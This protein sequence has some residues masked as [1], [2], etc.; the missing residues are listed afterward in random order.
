MERLRSISSS[1]PL[2]GKPV[3]TELTYTNVFSEALMS[4]GARYPEVVAIT[5]A[6][7]SPT[8]LLDFATEFPERFFDVGICEQHAVTFAAGP[9]PA[10]VQPGVG[11]YPALP[12]AALRHAPL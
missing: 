6:M 3:K 1:E 10:G 8:G 2:T 11:G 5:A 9:G 4:A 12:P 7:P